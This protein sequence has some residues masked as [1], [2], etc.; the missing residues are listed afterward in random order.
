[1]GILW[2]VWPLD[3]EMCSWLDEQEV[4]YPRTPSRF[5]TGIEIKAV[6]SGLTAYSVKVNDNGLNAPW[7]ALLTQKG[8]DIDPEWAVLTI[9]DFSGDD[10]PQ[11]LYF[12]K[13][14]ESLIVE[15]LRRLAASTGPL[16]LIDDAGSEPSVITP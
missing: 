6:I 8:N 5:P 15:I 4:A 14:H 9:S 16:V 13:G 11:Q 7:Q 2:T 1:M 10:L 12:E 3:G